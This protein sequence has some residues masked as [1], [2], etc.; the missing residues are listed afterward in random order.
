MFVLVF[1]LYA[2]VWFALD[3]S[4][5]NLYLNEYLLGSEFLDIGF[6]PGNYLCVEA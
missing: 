3:I 1:L 5:P 6:G 4:S 2:G